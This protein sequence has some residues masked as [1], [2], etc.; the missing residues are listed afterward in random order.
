MQRRSYSLVLISLLAGALWMIAH[1][2]IHLPRGWPFPVRGEWEV[3]L[4]S[5]S[6]AAG[7]IP[8]LALGALHGDSPG[9]YIIALLAA[10]L[11]SLGM[12]PIV[13]GKVLAMTLGA[14]MAALGAGLA[15]S[16][17]EE[18]RSQGVRLWTGLLCALLFSFAWPGMHFFFAG[19][20]G[21]TPESL[22][23]QMLALVLA[24][25]P[26]GASGPARALGCGFAL[27]VAWLLSPL[28]LWTALAVP[29]LWL[30]PRA[31]QSAPLRSR[32]FSLWWLALGSAAPLVLLA[33]LLPDGAG[34]MSLFLANDMGSAGLEVS[35]GGLREHGAVID[36]AG[37]LLLIA[38]VARSLEGGAH[39]AAL[40]LRAVVL[41]ITAWVGVVAVIW[42]LVRRRDAL[43]SRPA[44]LALVAGSWCVPLS[45]LPLDFGFY[46]LAYRYWGIPLALSLVLAAVTIGPLFAGC[47]GP[48]IRLVAM[49]ALSVAMAVLVMSLPNSIVAPAVS[50]A[51][52]AVGSGAHAMDPRA[53]YSRHA[54]FRQLSRHARGALR[55]Q[56]S[57]GY[58]LALGADT[59]VS[60]LRGDQIE[61][62]W[63]DLRG[64]LEPR[65]W[66]A[67]LFGVGCGAATYPAEPTRLLERL[68]S[69]SNE[70]NADI[71][72]GYQFCLQGSGRAIESEYLLPAPAIDLASAVPQPWDLLPPRF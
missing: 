8:P 13:A 62:Q 66:R 3:L 32:L 11:I 65:S 14:A 57:E 36:R 63:L 5:M 47:A 27:S 50:A 42:T 7:D 64:Q 44:L 25:A 68:F 56:L 46:P 4:V 6:V 54:A 1:L 59:A 48:K 69:G 41:A 15:V 37:P 18:S 34:G 52:A 33:G 39:N 58:G 22:V 26:R 70:E 31:E 53:G 71:S 9:S 17:V 60:I 16:L 45:L 24:L 28:A 30:L 19:L 72:R 67:L 23:F 2:A 43:S 51:E 55:M 40:A 29:I 20:S 12:S 35:L 49:T 61:P 21:S 10:S 38:K